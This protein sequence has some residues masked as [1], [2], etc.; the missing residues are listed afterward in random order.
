MIIT[1]PRHVS[2]S[3]DLSARARIPAISR[4]LLATA[5]WLTQLDDKVTRPKVIVGLSDHLR[6]DIGQKPINAKPIVPTV[7][8]VFIG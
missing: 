7:H 2:Q 3:A 5:H 4:W 1:L 8:G 6:R